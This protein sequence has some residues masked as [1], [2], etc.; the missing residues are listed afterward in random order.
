MEF[1]DKGHLVVR[2]VC[3]SCYL[4]NTDL[5]VWIELFDALDPVKCHAA[6]SMQRSC[7]SGPLCSLQHISKLTA[8]KT[9]AL[10]L[11][12][13]QYSSAQ[14]QSLSEFLE[15]QMQ[16]AELV[17]SPAEFKFWLLRWFR[18]LVEDGEDERIRQVCMEFIGPFLSASKTSWQP[19]IKG[20]SKRSLVKELLALFALNLRMQRLYVELKELLEQSQET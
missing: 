13:S 20:I 17:G 14:R 15:C 11:E 18:H 2:L 9:A 8:P 16:G 3:G 1:T 19:T 4:F 12:I 7:P 6:I 5:R 10:P